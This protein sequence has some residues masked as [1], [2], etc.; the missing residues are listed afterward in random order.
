MAADRSAHTRHLWSCAR[1]GLWLCPEMMATDD[2]LSVKD[3]LSTPP[4]VSG[5]LRLAVRRSPL[6]VLVAAPLPAGAT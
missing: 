4:R 2:N 5:R 6:R 3:D 1:R